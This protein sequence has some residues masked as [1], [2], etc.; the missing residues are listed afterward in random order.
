VSTL[1]LYDE[2]LVKSFL[3]LGC[4]F[5]STQSI[6]RGFFL[7]KAFADFPLADCRLHGGDG[8]FAFY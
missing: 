5:W 3:G 4:P 2:R 1:S 6:S 7:S 8:D